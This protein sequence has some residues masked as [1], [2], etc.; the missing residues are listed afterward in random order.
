MPN[1]IPIGTD[2]LRRSSRN[3]KDDIVGILG[4]ITEWNWE[5]PRHG[6]CYL[7]IQPHFHM[8]AAIMNLLSLASQAS[9]QGDP[10]RHEIG[11][12]VFSRIRQE[13]L[14]IRWRGS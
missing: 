3:Q 1:R 13:M 11:T 4:G 7:P 5:G 2:Y 10:L 8:H 12:R 6:A 14:L 9:R